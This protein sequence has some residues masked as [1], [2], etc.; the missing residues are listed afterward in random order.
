LNRPIF[1]NF[2]YDILLGGCNSRV[3][4]QPFQYNSW[5]TSDPVNV[6]YSEFIK[7]VTDLLKSNTPIVSGVCLDEKLPSDQCKNG[8]SVLITGYR[9]VCNSNRSNCTDYIK[10]HNT[11]GQDWQ[12]KNR[13][14][15]IDANNYYQYL[16]HDKNTFAW[17]SDRQK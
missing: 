13:D 7:K 4:I 2:L 10:V 8:H 16:Y 15:W 6:I 1:D 11:W 14:G 5:P 9:Q 12:D 17:L 3:D